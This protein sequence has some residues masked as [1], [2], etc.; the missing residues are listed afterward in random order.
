MKKKVLWIVA[1]ILIFVSIAVTGY[2]FVSDYLNNIYAQD[3]TVTYNK[4]LEAL[5]QKDY[6]AVLNEAYEYNKKLI[7]STYVS[8]PFSDNQAKAQEYDNM[9]SLKDSDVMATIQIPQIKI[10]L[11]IYHGTSDDVLKKGIGHLSSSSLP[12]GGV[13]THAVLTGHTGSSSLKLFSDLNQLEIDDVFYIT[14]LKEKIAY[15]IDQ[16]KVVLPTETDDLQID[17]DEDYVTLVTCTPFGVNTHRLL[18]RGKRI[19]LEVADEVVAAKSDANSTWLKEYAKALLLGLI[20][21]IIILLVYFTIRYVVNRT[22]KK[23]KKVN[24]MLNVELAEDKD[25]IDE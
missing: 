7:G 8:D 22:K 17:A 4:A 13:G 24:E 5:S 3:E 2:P 6:D 10:N 11:P 23:R 18:V 25:D 19:S 21:L 12:V 14:C 15:Q 16:I 9:L 1:I 20:I